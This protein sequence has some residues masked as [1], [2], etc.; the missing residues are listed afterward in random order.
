MKRIGS[1]A[2]GNSEKNAFRRSK[3]WKEFRKKL[4]EERGQNCEVCG[5]KTA[6]LQCHHADDSLE[7]YKNLDPSKFFLVC[8]LCHQAISDL[9]RIKPE[10]RYRLRKPDWVD[11]YARF[12]VTTS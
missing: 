3:E 6:R 11:F 8:A 12:L 7:N 5:K 1:S 2:Y 10:N 4:I 9:S